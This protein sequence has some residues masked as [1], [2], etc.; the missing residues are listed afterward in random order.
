MCIRDRYTEE[1]ARRYKRNLLDRRGELWR[2]RV[3]VVTD[4]S[5][6]WHYDNEEHVLLVY[7]KTL[8]AEVT[9]I[10]RYEIPFFIFTK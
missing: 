4:E 2:V 6:M 5:M 7:I 1:P 9:G 3:I 8:M 10:F